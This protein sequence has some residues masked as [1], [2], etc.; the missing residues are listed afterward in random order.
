MSRHGGK[1]KV[2]DSINMIPKPEGSGSQ[3]EGRWRRVTKGTPLG[4]ETWSTDSEL[5]AGGF[6][7]VG[8]T[9]TDAGMSVIEG[10]PV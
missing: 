4:F 6:R 5:S 3:G 2:L 10:V 1:R 7:L 9:P 8:T